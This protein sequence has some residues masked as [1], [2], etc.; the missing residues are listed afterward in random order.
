MI[1]RE[2]EAAQSEVG[3]DNLGTTIKGLPYHTMD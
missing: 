3:E 1:E 2:R